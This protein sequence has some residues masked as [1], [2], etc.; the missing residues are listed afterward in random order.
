MFI[1]YNKKMTNKQLKHIINYFTCINRISKSWNDGKLKL[2]PSIANN[3]Q[4][5]NR[6]G[7]LL[8][9]YEDSI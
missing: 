3:L 5:E 7:Y 8:A 6:L 2:Y 9:I 1:E 4:L